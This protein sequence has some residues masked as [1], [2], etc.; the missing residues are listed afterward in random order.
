MPNDT[1]GCTETSTYEATLLPTDGSEQKSYGEKD[2]GIDIF[3]YAIIACGS[4]IGI[5]G[6][7]LCTF[8]LCR[9]KHGHHPQFAITPSKENLE[10]TDIDREDLKHAYLSCSD[11]CMISCA[12]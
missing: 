1:P 10:L 5:I 12:E 8:Y 11:D 7:L 9:N 2:T 3:G 6:T 4:V